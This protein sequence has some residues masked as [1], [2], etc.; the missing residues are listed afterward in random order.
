M[1]MI[2]RSCDLAFAAVLLL[3]VTPYMALIAIAISLESSGPVIYS[4]ERIGWQGR[5]I[6]ILKFRTM[7][8]A[9]RDDRSQNDPPITTVS[10]ALHNSCLDWLPA[11]LSLL[12]G[13][14]SIVGPRPLSPRE[15]TNIPAHLAEVRCSIKPGICGWADLNSNKGYD[16]EREIADDIYYLENRNVKLDAIIFVRSFVKLWRGH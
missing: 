10:R 15:F 13:D 7:Y 3:S 5:T 2:R 16:L 6:R 12:R 11:L 1:D 9:N 8:D 14:I 4:I